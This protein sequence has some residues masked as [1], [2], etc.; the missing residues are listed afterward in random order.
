MIAITIIATIVIS[1]LHSLSKSFIDIISIIAN[2]IF[3]DSNLKY[4]IS[5]K[6]IIYEKSK[7]A[8]SFVELFDKY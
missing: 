8:N 1:N 5:N 3:I 6:V 7:V 2:I 4:I